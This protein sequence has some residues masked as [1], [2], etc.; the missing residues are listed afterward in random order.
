MCWLGAR[1]HLSGRS[2]W[3]K[4]ARASA[5]D[6]D[7]PLCPQATPH[8]GLLREEE[9]LRDAE[10]PEVAASPPP[11]FH[12]GRP[13][14]FQASNS[15][16]H[17]RGWRQEWLHGELHSLVGRVLGGMAAR[18][19]L[20]EP[21]LLV[22]RGGGMAGASHPAEPGLL[23]LQVSPMKPLEI[24]TQ[25]SGPREWTLRSVPPTLPSSPLSTTD[26][27]VANIETGRGAEADLL[28]QG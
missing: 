19:A 18:M 17:C 21:H 28:L 3:G 2:W 14:P 16:F 24:K 5:A 4:G 9:L 13:L 25:C 23:C 10:A 12:S 1:P 20:W 6:T 7:V 15:L 22:G 8:G 11:D 26:L 27:W